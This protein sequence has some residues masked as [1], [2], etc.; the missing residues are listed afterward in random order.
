MILSNETS[1]QISSKTDSCSLQTVHYRKLLLMITM[2]TNEGVR[3]RKE[4]S[5]VSNEEYQRFWPL[6]AN[7]PRVRLVSTQNLSSSF[8]ELNHEN[9]KYK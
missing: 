8:D 2:I 7:I 3:P 5:S 9:I 4:F 6:Q 1:M